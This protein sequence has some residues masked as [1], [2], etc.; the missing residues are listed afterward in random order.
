MVYF[1]KNSK[2]TFPYDNLN[3]NPFQM[4]A[5]LYLFSGEV[6]LNTIKLWPN[7]SQCHPTLDTPHYKIKNTNYNVTIAEHAK[8]GQD[9]ITCEQYSDIKQ[10]YIQ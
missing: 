10:T 1:V 3:A 8:P 2:Y 5:S 9:Y 6:Q 4:E 7:L